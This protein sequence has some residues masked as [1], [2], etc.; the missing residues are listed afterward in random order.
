M[1]I[2]FFC[3]RGLDGV[4]R[5]AHT[6]GPN[7]AQS[8]SPLFRFLPNPIRPSVGHWLE[9]RP[10]LVP[11]GRRLRRLR[12]AGIARRSPKTRRGLSRSD[13]GS[14]SRRHP[15]FGS[16][17]STPFSL[18]DTR[19]PCCFAGAYYADI[20][21]ERAG[22]AGRF[23]FQKLASGMS[24]STGR[25]SARASAPARAAAPAILTPRA[26]ARTKFGCPAY[27][28]VWIL[29]AICPVSGAHNG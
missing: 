28:L 7:E 16:N 22:M 13:D 26:S 5:E 19:S 15:E 25:L 12:H 24:R 6:A 14:F 20:D 10:L 27:E 11:A 2:Y 9:G 1:L 29:S 3:S 17:L 8:G 4:G 21:R 18:P 23:V